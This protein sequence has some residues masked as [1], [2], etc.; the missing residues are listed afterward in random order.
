[1]DA[2]TAAAIVS[3]RAQPQPQP[4]AQPLLPGT[5]VTALVV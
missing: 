2:V 3:P 1:M 4:S 5:V